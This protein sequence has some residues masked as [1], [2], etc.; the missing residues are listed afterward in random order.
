MVR[1]D[2]VALLGLQLPQDAEVRLPRHHG[3]QTRRDRAGLRRIEQEVR[4]EV[5]HDG[6]ATAGEPL[7]QLRVD[8]GEGCGRE[9]HG[10]APD[11]V[12]RDVVRVV[13]LREV[14]EEVEPVFVVR[15]EHGDGA[16]EAF[17]GPGLVDSLYPW[18]VEYAPD[19]PQVEID[20]CRDEIPGEG[21]GE[22]GGEP[23]IHYSASHTWQRK[24]SMITDWG[25]LLRG[26][27]PKSRRIRL[28]RING[29]KVRQRREDH[30]LLSELQTGVEPGV[31]SGIHNRKHGINTLD[32]V[33]A[34]AVPLHVLRTGVSD[35]VIGDAVIA[36]DRTRD[37]RRVRHLP[38]QVVPDQKFL[39]GEPGDGVEDHLWLVVPRR[40]FF[41]PG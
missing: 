17:L 13:Q 33:G 39:D 24:K 18:I 1:D 19:E 9:N 10:A 3:L 12:V 26:I 20:V 5:D 30:V 14:G 32:D 16:F 35:V 21:I 22:A 11:D 27:L 37:A 41:F 28:L 8:G 7:V 29:H 25:V 36:E 34:A 40:G 38:D 31:D 2:G 15:D 23:I 4:A 6:W